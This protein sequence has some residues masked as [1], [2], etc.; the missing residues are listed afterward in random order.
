M[1]SLLAERLHRES[2]L[3]EREIEHI[4]ML[5]GD[6]QLLSD[7]S[8]ADLVLWV[9]MRDGAWRAVAHVRPNTG[10]M[11][12]FEDI[13]G[14]QAVGDRARLLERARTEVAVLRRG[15]PILDHDHAIREEA[16]PLRAGDQVAA[17]VTRHTNLTAL[18]TPS[19]LELSYQGLAAALV[20]MIAAGE[21]PSPSAPTGVRRGAPRVSDGV[22]HL[23]VDGVT[24]YASPNAMSAIHRLGHDGD[25][26]G[27]ALATVLANALRDEAPV[28]EALAMVAMGRAAWRADVTTR[29]AAVAMR[30]IPLTE[31]GE[32]VGALILLRDVTE[33]RRRESELLSKEATIREIHHR[34]KNNLQTVA[35][36]LRLQARRLPEGGGR[37]A[38]LEAVRRVGTIATVHETLSHGF[39]ETVDFDEIARR[40][41]QA[42]VEVATTDVPIAS[43][44]TGSFGRLRAED[45][46]PLALIISEL[47]QNAV[48]HGLAES[49]GGTVRVEVV[50]EPHE[51]ADGD[52]LQ[53]AIS[54]D[55][56]G[57]PPGFR[58][59][60]AG[61][62]TQIVNSLVQGLRGSIRWE[63]VEPHGTRVRFFARLRPLD[64]TP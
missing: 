6:W 19:R 27:E 64:Q 61:L 9:L 24:L 46:M 29:S 50:R 28:D 20:R 12:F 41:L 39:D 35:A 55:G 14:Q 11:V 2:D 45:A 58:P 36:L 5:L 23:G 56:T 43:E 40:G 25:I 16:V 53:V 17:I 3:S 15:G 44:L 59:G 1:A 51:E 8:F 32:R 13:V 62:G 26:I 18:R 37:E 47:V 4:H 33:L 63:D 7:L 30:A 31:A 10:Q 60:K 52:V 38:L 54:D 57:I 22:V 49:G 48:E 42:I 21:W 34:V